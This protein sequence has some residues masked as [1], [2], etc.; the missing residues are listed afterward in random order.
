M[1]GAAARR[2]VRVFVPLALALALAPALGQAHHGD[3][4]LDYVEGSGHFL[5][6]LEVVGIEP[7]DLASFAFA[8]HPCHPQLQVLLDYAPTNASAA[9]PGAAVEVPFTFQV[10]IV[11]V[12]TG[13]KLP[14]AVMTFRAPGSA[15]YTLP[16]A[17][18]RMGPLRADLYLLQ[19]ADA[20][21]TLRIRGWLQ[22]EG[23]V[24]VSE[25]EANPAGADAGHEWIELAN[26]GFGPVD[27]SG[28]TVRALHGAPHERTLANGT[29]IDG[30]GHL[31]VTF[32]AQFLDNA[33]EVVT[34]TAPDGVEFARTPTLRDTA[35]DARTNQ[36][37]PEMGAAWAFQAGTPGLP[38]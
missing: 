27:L 3:T 6:G 35:N 37:V 38:N 4:L 17:N 26:L 16:P 21:W 31:V 30:S 36:L 11:D 2:G 7:I 34:L 25:V 24:I 23:C 32:P 5:A 1:D 8:A 28:W 18:A 19:G 13:A 33:A 9:A 22:T 12:A 29:T 10:E 15:W 20:D 14:G